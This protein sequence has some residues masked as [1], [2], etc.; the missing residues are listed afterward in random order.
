MTS[1]Q[2][3][4]GRSLHVYQV[5][6]RIRTT[7]SPIPSQEKLEQCRQLLGVLLGG[8]FFC[9]V[10][11]RTRD[12]YEDSRATL[13]GMSRLPSRPH[14]RSQRATSSSFFTDHSGHFMIGRARIQIAR[15]KTERFESKKWCCLCPHSQCSRPS[16]PYFAKAGVRKTRITDPMPVSVITNR[17]FLHFAS[18]HESNPSPTP[19]SGLVQSF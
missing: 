10:T 6:P 7:V 12:R 8:H 18:H 13:C 16:T 5:V 1:R 15:S 3:I 17:L 11:P 19:C 9:P 4:I 14:D 2:T